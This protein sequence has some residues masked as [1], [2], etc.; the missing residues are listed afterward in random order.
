MW[1]CAWNNT[2]THSDIHIGVTE[3][4]PLTTKLAQP[5]LQLESKY[6][7]PNVLGVAT[8]AER[9][10]CYA[11]GGHFQ[12]DRRTLF[13]YPT[14]TPLRGGQNTTGNCASV[15]LAFLCVIYVA[16]CVKV[17]AAHATRR[18]RKET[19]QGFRAFSAARRES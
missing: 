7:P 18:G 3:L 15:F 1:E 11:G 8:G 5:A 9:R 16:E 19:K 12:T 2:H 4:L 10:H 14:V 6:F 17:V 13:S